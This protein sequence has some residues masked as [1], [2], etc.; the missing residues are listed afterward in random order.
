MFIDVVLEL[1]FSWVFFMKV[2]NDV[3][4][5]VEVL[6]KFLSGVLNWPSIPFD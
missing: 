2:V 5:I 6:N 1:W 4:G 3:F